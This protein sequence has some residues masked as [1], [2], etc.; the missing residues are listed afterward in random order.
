M[1]DGGKMKSFTLGSG[2]R[3]G[4]PLLP[5]LFSIVLETLARTIGQEREMQSRNRKEGS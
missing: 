3:Q 5:L 4:C 1:L 2:W